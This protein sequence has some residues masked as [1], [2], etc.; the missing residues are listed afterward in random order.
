MSVT[1]AEFTWRLWV[2]GEGPFKGEPRNMGRRSE[3]GAPQTIPQTWWKRLETFLTKRADYSEP[4]RKGD[5][6]GPVTP[7]TT[8]LQLS[9]NFHVREFACHDGRQVPTVAIPA[10]KL[11]AQKLLEP[12]RTTFGPCHVLSGYRPVDYNARI[13]GAKFSQHIYELT[14]ESVAADLVFRIGTPARWAALADQLQ[15]G[16][17][18]RYD[19]SGFVHV[20]NRPTRARWTG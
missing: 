7:T 3:T 2:L 4:G 8:G 1:Q 16:G 14:P 19:S 17:V 9:T 15:A 6:P 13:G 10:L 5:A 11:L 18:G 12:M 20:D